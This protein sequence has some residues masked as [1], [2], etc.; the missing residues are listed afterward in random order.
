MREILGPITSAA[1]DPGWRGLFL[2]VLGAAAPEE[3]AAAKDG[4]FTAGAAY[5][6][7]VMANID[8]GI[9]RGAAIL[10]KLD[11]T[12]EVDGAA[13]GIEGAT[14]FVNL[15]FVHGRA[16]SGKLVGDA[17]VTSNIEAPSALRPLEA[18]IEL[19]L[20]RG[21]AHAKFGL[22]DLNSEFDVQ[23]VGAL[24]INSS[25]GIGPDFSQSGLNGP[26]IFPTTAGAIVLRG[27]RGGWTGRLGFFDAV[28]GDPD[29]PKRIRVG[30]P[31]NR[32][33]LAVAEVERS[34]GEE[35]AVKIGA[36]SYSTR[37]DAL[38]EREADGSPRRISG[39]RG[40]YATV[41]GRLA[42]KAG[43]ALDGWLRVGVADARINPISTTFS[44]GISWGNDDAAFGVAVSHARLG[45]A[46]RR[47]AIALGE[48]TRAAETN[49]EITYSKTIGPGL[50][51]Q[52]DLQYVIDP[53]W[54]SDPDDALVVGVRMI[55]SFP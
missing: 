38:D 40:A 33:L 6:L 7:D 18:W 8:G 10:G 9:D 15:Q 37:F 3:P 4:P 36:W 44:G 31:G 47:A 54:R 16:L 50:I 52:P 20:A 1:V 13:F 2:A 49:I 27:E 46:A 35:N 12:V 28:A 30:Y 34:L 53:S 24:F 26:S 32:G 41:E 17:Q 23:R 11:A 45:D 14:G 51:I 19:P 39:N 22:I 5:T 29:R 48:E 43:R 55:A 42:E 21:A 25:H